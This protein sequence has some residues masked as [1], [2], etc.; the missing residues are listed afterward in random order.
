MLC[1]WGVVFGEFA[2]KSFSNFFSAMLKEKKI[3]LVGFFP[4]NK[5]EKFE[6]LEIFCKILQKSGGI[7]FKNLVNKQQTTY[8]TLRSS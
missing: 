1:K 3:K 8:T 7:E 5:Y 4:F 2:E 6:N